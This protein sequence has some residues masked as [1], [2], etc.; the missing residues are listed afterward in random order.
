MRRDL[1]VRSG[2]KQKRNF[3]RQWV[4][5]VRPREQ[6]NKRKEMKGAK[7]RRKDRKEE[8]KIGWKKN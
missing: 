8:E 6:Q 4:V 3:S 1:N 7:T 2:A 5:N